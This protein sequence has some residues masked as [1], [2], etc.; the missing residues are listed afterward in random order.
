MFADA[1]GISLSLYVSAS[2]EEQRRVLGEPLINSR[3]TE[4]RR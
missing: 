3:Y 4:H 1:A 2:N